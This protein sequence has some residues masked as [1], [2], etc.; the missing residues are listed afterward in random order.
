MPKINL[1]EHFLPESRFPLLRE[2][3]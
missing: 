1:L 2:M 3:L